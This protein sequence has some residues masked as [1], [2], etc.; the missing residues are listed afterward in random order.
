MK[1]K[2]YDW[3]E[4]DFYLKSFNMIFFAFDS[5]LVGHFHLPASTASSSNP[6]TITL[7]QFQQQL[8]MPRKMIWKV[9]SR[10]Q[11]IVS[12]QTRIQYLKCI[13]SIHN[14]IASLSVTSILLREQWTRGITIT[15]PAHHGFFPSQV[16][17]LIFNISLLKKLIYNTEVNLC[18]QKRWYYRV[19]QGSW[20]S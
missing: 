12:L 18:I 5:G 10:G 17:K 8:L 9:W 16:N 4:Q 19:C 15:T 2:V 3:I 7:S 20:P 1:L 6:A 11:E 13:E 14:R